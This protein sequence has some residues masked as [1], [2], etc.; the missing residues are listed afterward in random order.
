[1]LADVQ[2]FGIIPEPGTALLAALSGLC[3]ML[4]RRR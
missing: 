1:M 4:R 2:V 3:L